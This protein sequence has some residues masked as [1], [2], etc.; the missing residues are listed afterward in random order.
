M[1]MGSRLRG[2]DGKDKGW[3]ASHPPPKPGPLTVIPAKAGIQE[4]KTDNLPD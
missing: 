2:K 1:G 4:G 3:V